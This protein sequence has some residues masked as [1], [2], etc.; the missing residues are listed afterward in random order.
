MM[1]K[2]IFFSMI[3]N[4]HAVIDSQLAT[5]PDQKHMSFFLNPYLDWFERSFHWRPSL[6]DEGK[7]FLTKAINRVDH[8]RTPYHKDLDQF[9]VGQGFQDKKPHYTF[10]VYIHEDLRLHPYLKNQKPLFIEWSPKEGLCFISEIKTFDIKWKSIPLY[11]DTLYLKHVCKNHIRFVS[12]LTYYEETSIKNP[13]R[14][15]SE[16]ELRTYDEKGLLKVQ[17]FVKTTHSGRLPPHHVPFVNAH[18]EAL[19]APFDKYSVDRDGNII[20]Y[21]P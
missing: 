7:A 18:G 20:I 16:S 17:Y 11:K 14:G 3:L 4:A 2:I 13:F 8:W 1:V 12:M 21:Y 5:K 10:R 9:L 19:L 15:Q 6:P